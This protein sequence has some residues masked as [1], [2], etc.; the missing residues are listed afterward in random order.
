MG[1]GPNFSRNILIFNVVEAQLFS[2]ILKW[3]H[4]ERAWGPIFQNTIWAIINELQA[5]IYQ[6]N[7]FGQF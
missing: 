4:F 3:A 5:Q 2:K 7:I 1:F 6:N